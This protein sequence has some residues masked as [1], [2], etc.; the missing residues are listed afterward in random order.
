MRLRDIQSRFLIDPGGTADFIGRAQF[1]E[2]TWTPGPQAAEMRADGLLDDS[3]FTDAISSMALGQI[4]TT[5][6]QRTAPILGNAAASR[7][8]AAVSALT[9]RPICVLRFEIPFTTDLRLFYG[10]TTSTDTTDPVGSDTPVESYVGVQMS[11]DRGDTGL[12]PTAHLEGGG[13]S[14]QDEFG[15]V[16]IVPLKYY[17]L[18]MELAPGVARFTIANAFGLPI[19][20]RKI[21]TNM[22][23]D[24]EG[25]VMYAGVQTRSGAARSQILYG[26]NIRHRGSVLAT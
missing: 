15:D 12:R 17:F 4:G 7:T 24:D 10:F 9:M 13:V 11:T 8:D 25:L 16:V 2:G 6:E 1:Q 5:F 3:V 22:P 26:G 23:D 21:A 19:G 20:R 14:L 18:L